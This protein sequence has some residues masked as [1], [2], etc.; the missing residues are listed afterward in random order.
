M[1]FGLAPLAQFPDLW[2]GTKLFVLLTLKN[3]SFQ[4]TIRHEAR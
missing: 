4:S 2:E 3:Y 1:V